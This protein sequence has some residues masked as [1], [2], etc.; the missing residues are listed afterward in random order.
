MKVTDIKTDGIFFDNEGTSDTIE[1]FKKYAEHVHDLDGIVYI[2]PGYNYPYIVN[3]LKEGVADVA[4]VYEFESSKVHHMEMTDGG[5]HP[6]QLSA[7]LGDVYSVSEMKRMLSE[8]ADVGIGTVYVYADSY[9]SL[10]PFFLELVKESGVTKI[11][12]S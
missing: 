6:R 3:Y 8:T 11:R 4:N 2:N 10:P 7:I 1:R 5:I 12:S 9:Y